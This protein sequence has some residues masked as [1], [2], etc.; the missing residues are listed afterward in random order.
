IY[1]GDIK[2]E[3]VLVTSWNWI[4]LSDF[5]G[6]KPTYLPEGELEFGEKDGAIT[7]AMDIFSLG[8]V[9]AEVFLEGAPIFSLAQLFKYRSGEYNPDVCLNKIEDPDIRDSNAAHNAIVNTDAD[10]KIERIYHEFD[11]IAFLLGFYGEN[12]DVESEEIVVNHG[13]GD[14]IG[15]SSRSL[16]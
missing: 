6:Y 11:K 5:A 16:G 9:I 8:C 7:P 14:K 3:N 1:H 4:Y 10:D 2:T 12:T 15:E 13:P